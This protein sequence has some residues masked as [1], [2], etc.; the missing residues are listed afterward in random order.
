M[1]N[2]PIIPFSILEKYRYAYFFINSAFMAFITVLV[3]KL[4]RGNI[5][6]EYLI[7]QFFICWVFMYPVSFLIFEV[8]KKQ[9]KK[10]QEK[11]EK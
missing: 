8:V 7:L 10:T 2:N 9:H 1:K 3:T 5:F 11:K 4:F 6:I